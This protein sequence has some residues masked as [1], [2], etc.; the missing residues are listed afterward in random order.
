[1][2]T[3]EQLQ[4]NYDAF[5]KRLPELLPLHGGKFALMHEGEIVEFYDSARDAY[6]SGLKAYPDQ[7]FSI[8]EVADRAANLGF[9]T[10]ALS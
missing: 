3:Q 2:A 8:Q 6:V 10:Y 4:K 7:N 9:L 1:M 5:V